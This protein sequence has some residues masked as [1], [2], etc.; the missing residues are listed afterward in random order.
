MSF[1]YF[2]FKTNER[3]V[4]T[5]AAGYEDQDLHQ[6]PLS[7]AQMQSTHATRSSRAG[8]VAGTIVCGRKV[9]IFAGISTRDC[10][11]T[12]KLFISWDLKA[13]EAQV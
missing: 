7:D 11:A 4:K 6:K 13:C 5:M 10:I 9:D 1:T 8:Q 12:E 2:A 3:E